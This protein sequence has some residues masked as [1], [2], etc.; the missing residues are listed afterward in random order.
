MEL[1]DRWEYRVRLYEL[2]YVGELFGGRPLP[3]GDLDQLGAE[4][5]ELVSAFVRP[6]D[7]A[8]DVVCLLKRRRVE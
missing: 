4:G 8:G 3:E 5:W 1:L 6:R 2:R 7:A